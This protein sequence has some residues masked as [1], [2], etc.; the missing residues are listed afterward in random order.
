MQTNKETIAEISSTATKTFEQAV[1]EKRALP[2]ECF[3]KTSCETIKRFKSSTIPEFKSKDNKTRYEAN[4]N[5][6]GKIDDAI[7]SIKKRKHLGMTRETEG[8]KA[9]ILK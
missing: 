1:R 6:L 9:L 4:T 3:D 8:G 7:H 2:Q 5:I